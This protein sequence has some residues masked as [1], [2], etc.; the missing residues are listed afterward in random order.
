MIDATAKPGALDLTIELG[1]A[2]AQP[3]QAGASI[4]VDGV[5]LTVVEH[6]EGHARFDLM[7]ETLRRTTLGKLE[8]GMR[9]NVERAALV[10]TEIGGHMLSGHVSALVEI[11]RIE[12]SP[13]NHRVTIGV[14]AG[15]MKYLF[16]QGFV[17]L[18]GVS[19]TIVEI[20]AGTST[21][22]VSLIPETLRRTTFG[23]KDEGASLNLE[24]DPSTRAVVDTTERFLEAIRTRASGH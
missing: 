21:F 24:I 18:D 23:F 10:G 11:R 12:R 6:G 14:A 5:C 20:D 9:V 3:L 1:A 13:N 16:P 2:G 4:A 22:V 19:L 8:S 17:A 7:E 15:W